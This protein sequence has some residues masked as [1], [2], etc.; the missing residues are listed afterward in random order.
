VYKSFRTRRQL[1]DCAVLVEQSWWKPLDFALLKRSSVS[2]FEVVIWFFN[3]TKR[4]EYNFIYPAFPFQS[5]QG[6]L[7]GAPKQQTKL[8]WRALPRPCSCGE[9][10]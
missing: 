9:Q 5:Q 3:K 6:S 8:P 2:F 1:A 10:V 4:T 7:A